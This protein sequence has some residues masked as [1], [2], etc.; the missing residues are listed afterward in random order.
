[1]SS[2][3][4][5]AR[6]YAKAAFELAQSQGALGAW[7]QALANTA[8]AAS[9]EVLVEWLESPE[10]DRKKAVALMRDVAGDAVDASFGR[11][12]EALADNDRLVLLPQISAMFSTLRAEAENRLDVRVV[13]A[14]PLNDEQVARMTEALA[15]RFDCSVTLHNEVDAKVLGGAVIYAGD[16][17]IDGSLRGRLGKLES[18]LL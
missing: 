15:R 1:M 17:V 7:G 18:S 12:L 16:Q 8:L 13:S 2:L 9:D 6:P 4:T 3:T 14:I 10:L 5:L 11:F